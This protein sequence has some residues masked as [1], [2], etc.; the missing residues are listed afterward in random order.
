MKVHV[1]YTVDVGDAYR[2]ALRHHYGQCGTLATRQEV[3]DHL[4]ASGESQD[5]DL[6]AEFDE[7]E[8]CAAALG[9]Q[10]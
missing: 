6:M 7:C 4:Q 2:M 8:D 1:D 10:S 9:A 5:D 3:R